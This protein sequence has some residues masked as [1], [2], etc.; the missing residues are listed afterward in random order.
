NITS[1]LTLQAGVTREG[2]VAGAR[3][4]QSNVTLDGVDINDQQIEATL[5]GQ[6]I[7]NPLDTP[8]LR[9]NSEAIEEFRVTTL[10]ANANQGR[11]SAAQV[12]LVTKTGTKSLHGD[13][14][15][16]KLNTC[17]NAHLIL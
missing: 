15:M 16:D 9:L 11:S 13:V 2:Y 1:L 7:T 17:F 8:V 10:N 14:F 6:R 3:S 4:D 5:A 12:H